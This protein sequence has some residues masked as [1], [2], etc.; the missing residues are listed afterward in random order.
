[1]RTTSARDAAVRIALSPAM[2]LIAALFWS[3]ASADA[4]QG[5]SVEALL[6]QAAVARRGGERDAEIRS[7][8]QVL[9]LDAAQPAAHARLAELS[10]PAPRNGRMDPEARIRRAT[11]HP[12]PLAGDYGAPRTVV[13]SESHSVRPD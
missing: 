4:P 7:L 12:A 1:M 9:D 5:E 11:A 6:A 13:K 8:L 10:G 3:P 2:L